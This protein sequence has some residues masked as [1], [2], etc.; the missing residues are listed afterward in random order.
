MTNINGNIIEV[1]SRTL[2]FWLDMEEA[3]DY[4]YR[5]WGWVIVTGVASWQL[6]LKLDFK[7]SK[8]SFSTKPALIYRNDVTVINGKGSVN[9]DNS[10]FFVEIPKQNIGPDLYDVSFHLRNKDSNESVLQYS[11]VSVKID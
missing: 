7:G 11:F 3:D 6:D 10:G 1:D 8:Y 2:E 9:H 5:M 4:S